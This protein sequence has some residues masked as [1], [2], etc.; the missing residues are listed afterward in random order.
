MA[1]LKNFKVRTPGG[2]ATVRAPVGSTDEQGMGFA[3]QEYDKA[4]ALVAPVAP[5]E[6]DY[7]KMDVMEQMLTA[8]GNVPKSA[9]QA[10][11]DITAPIHSPVQRRCAVSY[12][13]RARQ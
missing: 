1:E 10:A 13:R 12:P 2:V 8:A 9:V 5:Q 3:K 6:Q 4:Q 7:S 11:K